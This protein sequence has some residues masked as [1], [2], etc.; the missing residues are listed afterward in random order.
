MTRL[1]LL[2][3]FV[4]APF[5]AHAAVSAGDLPQGT[6]WYV[7]ADLK[8]MRST[9]S[10]V[11]LQAWLEEEVFSE[12]RDD[13]GIDLGKEVDTVTAFSTSPRGAVIVLEG[14]ISDTTREKLLMLGRLAGDMEEYSHSGKTY[15]HIGQEVSQDDDG[16]EDSLQESAYFSFAVS[17]KLLAATDESELKALLDANGKIVGTG[18]R[19]NSV[20]VFSADKGFLQ[21]GVQTKE[22]MNSGFDWDSDIARNIEQ[23]ALLVAD[24]DG[25]IAIEA[26]LVS[27]DPEMATSVAAIINGLIG[28]QAF[29]SELDPELAD[30]LQN[31]KVT[32]REKAL[33]IKIVVDPDVIIS[34]IED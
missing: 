33:S 11:H 34:L 32:V 31:T 3:L 25:L 27:A 16:D 4:L 20:F 1:S 30:I 29:S 13:L 21:A 14:D 19:G 8:E 23:V 26:R 2:F 12:I 28:L 9:D 22:L 7:H 6:M 17:G 24:Q 15:Y 18:D 10:G 5:A